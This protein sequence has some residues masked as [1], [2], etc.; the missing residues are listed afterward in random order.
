MAAKLFTVIGGS[1]FIGRYVVQ[2]LAAQGH[3]VRVA[4]R[5]PNLAQFLKPLGAVGQIQIVQAN[6]RHAGSIAS[7]VAGADGVVNLVGLLFESGHQTFDDVQAEGAATVAKACAQAGVR[8]LV[9]VSAIGADIE[10]EANYARTKGAAEAAVREAFSAVTVLRPS[11]VFGPEDG[12]FNR[13]AGLAKLSPLVFPVIAGDAKLQPVYV[14]DVAEAISQALQSGAH[15]GHT[16]ELGGPKVYT[17]RELVRF[18]LT[19]IQAKRALIEVPMGIARLQAL[20]LGLLPNPIVTRDQLKMLETPNVVGTGGNG[21]AAFGVS[22][23]P[24][25]AI[26]PG[27]LVR[28]RP[29]GA[30]TQAPLK[31]VKQ[32]A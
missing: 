14:L 12:F 29:K 15:A 23:T 6:V 27:Y 21:F 11:V 5:N 20:V 4:V 31:G 9:H 1:G 22:P 18:I 24:V 26:V 28:Y 25:E 3:R 16:Y 8:A 32:E 17:L 13:F 10:S 2:K 19:E 7:A 30:F